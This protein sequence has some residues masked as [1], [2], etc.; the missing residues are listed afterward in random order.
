MTDK[1]LTRREARD[2]ERQREMRLSGEPAELPVSSNQS[3]TLE[4]KTLVVESVPDITNITM[5]LPDSGAVLTTG[6]IELPWLNKADTGQ[7]QV[8]A[9]AAEADTALAEGTVDTNSIG[10]APIA[11]RHHERTRRRSSVFPTR[12]RKGWG[13]VHLVLVSAFLLLAMLCGLLAAFFL[14][15]ITL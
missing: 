1:P 6:S 10:I 12:L 15:L 3:A 14:G 7:T 8:I 11:A 9:E 13:V 2:I 5:V 4:P